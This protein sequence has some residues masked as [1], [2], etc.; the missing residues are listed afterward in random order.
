[1]GLRVMPQ[2]KETE[3]EEQE[4]IIMDVIKHTTLEDLIG[5]GSDEIHDTGIDPGRIISMTL[6]KAREDNVEETVEQIEGVSTIDEKNELRNLLRENCEKDKINIKETS[7]IKILKSSDVEEKSGRDETTRDRKFL[8]TAVKEKEQIKDRYNFRERQ[9][10]NST[11]ENIVRKL[12]VRKMKVPGETE[13]ET[14][15]YDMEAYQRE[16]NMVTHVGAM[17]YDRH[18]KS[19]D[20]TDESL[21]PGDN[22][23]EL[24]YINPNQSWPGTNVWQSEKEKWKEKEFHT[25]KFVSH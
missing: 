3:D 7:N 24:I 19:L 16:G 23:T 6:L 1:M 18:M 17:T 10:S 15:N 13:R 14:L 20:G 12:K 21:K 5:E 22:R 25:D 4:G 9:R 11:W 2:R 8:T